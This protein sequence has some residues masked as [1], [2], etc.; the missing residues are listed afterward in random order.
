MGR[1][2]YATLAYGI[3]LGGGEHAWTFTDNVDEYGRWKPAWA[4]ARDDGRT[5]VECDDD[6]DDDDGWGQPDLEQRLKDSGF[7]DQWNLG[8]PNTPRCVEGVGVTCSGYPEDEGAS[9]VLRVWEATVDA[10]DLAGRIDF[11]ELDQRRIAEVW[12]D[13]LREAL[14]ALGVHPQDEPGWLL[15]AHYG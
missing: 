9:Y 5:D 7:S 15:L 10:S 6:D 12:D 13:K 14:D 2:A 11:A 3:P 8:G 1:Y 4:A